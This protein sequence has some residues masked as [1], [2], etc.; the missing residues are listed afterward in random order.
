MCPILTTAHRTRSAPNVPS[1]PVNPAM[2]MC[3]VRCQATE[4]GTSTRALV[5]LVLDVFSV[6]L[7]PL[8]VTG[9]HGGR[10]LVHV[11]AF[12]HEELDERPPRT[13]KLVRN[14]VPRGRVQRGIWDHSQLAGQDLRHVRE[15]SHHG[16]PPLTR[17]AAGGN[18]RAVCRT[19][20]REGTFELRSELRIRRT[21]PA[22]A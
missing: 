2:L 15:V 18:G 22:Q 19:S 3:L 16:L 1:C 17:T 14:V 13:G 8:G 6:E 21:P 20:E 4:G 5:T 10:T 9:V 11:N 7:F 12:G